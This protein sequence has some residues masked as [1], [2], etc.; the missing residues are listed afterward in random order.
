MLYDSRFVVDK[1]PFD[2]VLAHD[3]SPPSRSFFTLGEMIGIQSLF[4][5]SH[6]VERLVR[7]A[8]YNLHKKIKYDDV[9]TFHGI[10]SPS[11]VWSEKKGQC[12]EQDYFLKAVLD[13]CDV[14]TSW[15]VMKNFWSGAKSIHEVCVH[16]SLSFYSGNRR[17]SADLVFGEVWNGVIPSDCVVLNNRPFSFGEFASFYLC[18]AGEDF[19][20]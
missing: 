13:C 15:R 1:K 11:D 6:G 2:V 12:I 14:N 18:Y 9:H 8:V 17:L 10:R 20:F 4:D 3:Y 7:S 16:P 5:T 19:F